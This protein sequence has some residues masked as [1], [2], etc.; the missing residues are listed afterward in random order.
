M[1]ILLYKYGGTKMLED[2]LIVTLVGMSTVFVFLIVLVFCVN[3][4]SFIMKLINKYFPEVVEEKEKVS[5]VNEDDNIIAAIAAY[6]F[7]V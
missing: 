6:K 5:V 2:G 7:N 1:F 3:L 4:T